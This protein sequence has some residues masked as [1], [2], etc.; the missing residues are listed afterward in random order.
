[1]WASDRKQGI[2]NWCMAYCKTNTALYYSNRVVTYLLYA[3]KYHFKSYCI[4]L[5]MI[6]KII[7]R[8]M[9]GIRSI[10]EK[11]TGNPE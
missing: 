11:T 8:V 2:Y 1:M 3:I 9:H 5:M 6:L 7:L 10:T 4:G